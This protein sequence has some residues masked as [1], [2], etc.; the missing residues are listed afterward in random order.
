[1]TLAGKGY[2]NLQ[3]LYKFYLLI[4]SITFETDGI[5]KKELFVKKTIQKHEKFPRGQRVKENEKP[6]VYLIICVG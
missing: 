4:S 6:H 1:M 2:I 5:P 3:G